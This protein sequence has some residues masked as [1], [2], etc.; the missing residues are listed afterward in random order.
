MVRNPVLQMAAWKRKKVW[1]LLLQG[2][3][4]EQEAE[5]LV[6][7]YSQLFQLLWVCIPYTF[8]LNHARF[9]QQLEVRLMCYSVP[10]ERL[11]FATSCLEAVP[12]TCGLALSPQQQARK[13]PLPEW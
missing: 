10:S 9:R 3:W 13:S 2:R 4:H 7:S 8:T 6:M 11:R 1:V 12:P 5:S